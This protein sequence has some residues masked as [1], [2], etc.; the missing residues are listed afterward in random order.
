MVTR[1]HEMNP[2]VSFVSSS[3]IK[4]IFR[5]S[6]CIILAIYR[7]AIFQKKFDFSLVLQFKGL[8]RGCLGLVLWLFGVVLWAYYMSHLALRIKGVIT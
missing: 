4:K 5:F 7:F 2:T 1:F 6:T 3:E 8:L